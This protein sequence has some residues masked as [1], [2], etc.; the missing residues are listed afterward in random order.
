MAQ[1][2]SVFARDAYLHQSP[3]D[4]PAC[5]RRLHRGTAPGGPSRWSTERS[6]EWQPL[7][8]E[9]VVEVKYDQ[10]TSGKGQGEEERFAID[11]LVEEGGFEPSVPR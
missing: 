10:V 7:R 8:P 2:G 6:R 5:R 9:L 11:S 3:C 4:H 1:T